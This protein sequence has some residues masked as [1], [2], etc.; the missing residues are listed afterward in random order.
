MEYVE[1]GALSEIVRDFGL[2]RE[3]LCVAYTHQ[4]LTGL[5]YLHAHGIIH[6]DIKGYYFPSLFTHTHI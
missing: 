1:E 5:V 3:S 2:L 6:R 4:I